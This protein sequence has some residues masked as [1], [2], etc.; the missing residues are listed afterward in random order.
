MVV[1]GGG[2]GG[3]N[4]RSCRRHILLLAKMLVLLG[5][6]VCQLREQQDIPGT[7]SVCTLRGPR[8][9]KVCHIEPSRYLAI[10]VFVRFFLFVCFLGGGERRG[11]TLHARKRVINFFLCTYLIG[12]TIR[13]STTT[14]K[15]HVL[16]LRTTYSSRG[17]GTRERDDLRSRTMTRKTCTFIGG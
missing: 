17:I 6:P 11:F 9:I 13:G 3:R 5:F 1:V 7:L 8:S 12:H 4:S 16:S 2:G 10:L 14:L 15:P